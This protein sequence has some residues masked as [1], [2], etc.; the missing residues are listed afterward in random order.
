M[1][2]ALAA[3]IKGLYPNENPVPLHAP[4]MLGAEK[5]YLNQCIDS[6][7]VSYVGPLVKQFEERI[8]KFTGASYAVAT[9][10]GT[11]ALHLALLLAGVRPGDEV[12]LPSLTFVAAANAVSYCGAHCIFLDVDE[13]SLG[14]APERLESFLRDHS[15]L[16]PGGE[17]LNRQSGRRISVCM[18]VHILG[19][20]ARTSDILSICQKYHLQMIED[21]SEAL[22]SYE[23]G[24]HCGTLGNLGVL[25]FNGNKVLTTGGGGMILTND[26]HLAMRATHLST[27]AKRPHSYKFFHDEV[28][29]NY[30]M[31]NLNAALGCAQAEKLEQALSNKRETA[32]MYRRFFNEH[33][34]R[35]VGEREGCTSNFWLNA[36]MLKSEGERDEL[37]EYGNANGIQMR[38]MWEALHSLPMYRSCQRDSLEVTTDIVARTVCLPSSVRVEG[39]RV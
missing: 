1:F 31:P 38:P 12:I 21:A 17:C 14:I 30:R 34:V 27:T 39:R 15:V 11:S 26:S 28:G 29:F 16:S 33:D 19:H 37:L 5:S 8:A 24:R 4:R 20:P 7:F 2:E 6:T 3:L 18:P 10:S 35:F 13:S 32:E 23:S 22:G 9:A 36:I 25:S